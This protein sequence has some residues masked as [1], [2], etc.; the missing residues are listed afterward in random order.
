VKPGLEDTFVAAWEEFAEW[1]AAQYPGSHAWL[2]RDRER[3]NTFISVGPWSSE[4]AIG[5]WRNSEGF[6]ERIGRIRELLQSF[7]ARTLD[8]AVRVDGAG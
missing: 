8:E 1:T 5:E 3:P 2:L 7:E 6:L 4:E